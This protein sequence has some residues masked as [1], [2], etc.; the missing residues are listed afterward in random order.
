VLI[1]TQQQSMSTASERALSDIGVLR[2]VFSHLGQGYWL[3]ASPVS[4][5]WKEL[6]EQL[7]PQPVPASSLP[8]WVV[9]QR[10]QDCIQTT[11]FEAAFQ[12]AASVREACEHG[13][14]AQFRNHRL[15]RQAGREADVPTLMAAQDLGL[16]VADEFINSAAGAG[17]LEV[18][19]LLHTQGVTLPVQLSVYAAGRAHV[20]VLRWL[21]QLG[22]AFDNY[23][24][25]SAAGR[26]CNEVLQYLLSEQAEFAVDKIELCRAVAQSGR[27]STLQY[28][29]EAGCPWADTIADQAAVSGSVEVMRWLRDQGA[30]IS[31]TTMQQAARHGHTELCQYL[32]AEGCHWDNTVTASTCEIG[33]TATLHWL[34]QQGCPMNADLCCT[35]AAGSGSIDVMRYLLE[36]GHATGARLQS[37][38]NMA[39]VFGQL[40]AAQWLRQQGA[41]WP[42]VLSFLGMPWSEAVLAWARAEGCTSPDSLPEL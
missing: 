8:F 36:A 38:L 39:G 33:Q 6:Y 18:L 32:C 17:Q 29:Q 30:T 28:L 3:F 13:L 19:K 2:Q 42:D 21:Q 10:N 11:S 7:Q 4:K 26:G 27:L 41:E 12:S 20:N 37:M 5:L 15:Q 22:I 25:V 34:L 14:Q 9:L 31:T 16:A 24:A 23:T 1:E 35:T 40:A